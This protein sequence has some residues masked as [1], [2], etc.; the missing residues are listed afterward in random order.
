ML[1]EVGAARFRDGAL[2]DLRFYH[3]QLG[4]GPGA[5]GL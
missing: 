2:R 4:A 3:R 5:F 1:G